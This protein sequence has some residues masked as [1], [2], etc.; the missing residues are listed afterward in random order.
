MDDKPSD[1]DIGYAAG[2][3]ICAQQA[4]W[5]CKAHIDRLEPGK[6]VKIRT[7]LDDLIA[8]LHAD[9]VT[10]APKGAPRTIG[11][12]CGNL[13]CTA[14]HKPTLFGAEG[15]CSTEATDQTHG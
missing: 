8:S 3:A 9:L 5:Q 10:R 1:H 14:K 4:L 13:G 7:A 12:W 2:W 15:A 11:Q 6:Q